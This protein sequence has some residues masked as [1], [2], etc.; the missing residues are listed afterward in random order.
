MRADRRRGIPRRK[1]ERA[2]V[3]LLHDV[4]GVVVVT[5][6]PSREVVR[7]IHMREER[8]IEIDGFAFV[9]Q[10][11]FFRPPVRLVPDC[12]RANFIPGCL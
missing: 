2:Q 3:R 12:E 11:R 6:Q 1:S 8:A 7:S 9:R 10:S 4:L 5:H